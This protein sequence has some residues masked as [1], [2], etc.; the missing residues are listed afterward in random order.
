MSKEKCDWFKTETEKCGYNKI[1]NTNYCRYHAY[2]SEFIDLERKNP[3]YCSSCRKTKP[4]IVFDG[5]VCTDCTKKSK[6]YYDIKKDERNVE[7]IEKEKLLPKI[8]TT[9]FLACS[10]CGK[11]NDPSDYI[12]NRGQATKQ[13][14]NCR[15]ANKRADIKR[16]DIID[17]Q[18]KYQNLSQAAKD[19]KQKRKKELKALKALKKNNVEN[20][21]G[22][23]DINDAV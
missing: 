4:M 20:E 3:K 13:C 15:E 1:G 11:L 2:I 22:S 21:D 19:K 7:Q 9:G 8:D 18:E 6:G 14:S 12:G 23:D 5:A 10:K 16:A 17:H